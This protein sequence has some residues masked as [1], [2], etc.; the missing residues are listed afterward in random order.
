MAIGI[1]YLI[2]SIGAVL[3]YLLSKGKT[4]RRK[5]IAWGIALMLPISPALAF[6]LGLTYAVSVGDG[7][8]ALIMVYI[9]PILFLIGLVMLLVG[10]FTKE[11]AKKFSGINKR[12]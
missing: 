2:A 6:S 4:K 3:A 9:F 12:N 1:G 5:Y 10:I 11:D 7:W 8:S